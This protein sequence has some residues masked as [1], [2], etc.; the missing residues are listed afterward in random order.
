MGPGHFEYACQRRKVGNAPVT[1]EV[2]VGVLLRFAREAVS[3]LQRPGRYG[4]DTRRWHVAR[5]ES[6]SDKARDG[7]LSA[8]LCDP[9]SAYGSEDSAHSDETMQRQVMLADLL[10]I[11]GG[12]GSRPCR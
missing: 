8:R 2:V 3:E 1:P 4:G 5:S 9:N 12:R 7:N 6:R 10:L 11:V